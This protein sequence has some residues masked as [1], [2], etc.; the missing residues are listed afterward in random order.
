MPAG[1]GPVCGAPRAVQGH[2]RAVDL[3][4]GRLWRHELHSHVCEIVVYA[5]SY[6][7]VLVY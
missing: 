1:R 5:V 7:T 3:P 6:F 4:G 2:W